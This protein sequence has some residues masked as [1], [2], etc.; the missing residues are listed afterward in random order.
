MFPSID[1]WHRAPHTSAQ[2]IDLITNQMGNGVVTARD[3]STIKKAHRWHEYITVS[4]K[5]F[6]TI[7]S[8][9]VTPESHLTSN[10]VSGVF[11]NNVMSAGAGHKDTYLEARFSEL[12]SLWFSEIASSACY[13]CVFTSRC[14]RSRN[15]SCL[16]TWLCYQL[17]AKPVNTT[18][19]EYNHILW[20]SLF[21]HEISSFVNHAYAI[22]RSDPIR[23]RISK[24]G[25][26]TA[27]DPI[28]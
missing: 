24:F 4:P 27:A 9:H 5:G 3:K 6:N 28:L 16:V 2:L 10:Y 7:C 22:K 18:A 15:C 23:S 12:W 26:S 13:D 17:I 11:G 20:M 1:D 25:W 14:V 19:T 21:R 8:M